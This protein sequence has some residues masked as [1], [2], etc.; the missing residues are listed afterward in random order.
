MVERY[1]Y[2]REYEDGE[3]ARLYLIRDN[4]IMKFTGENIPGVAAVAAKMECTW[5]MKYVLLLAPGV[6]T[7]HIVPPPV[8]TWGD[9]YESWTD[10]AQDLGV[11]EEEARRFAATEFPDIAERLDAVETFVREYGE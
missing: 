9:W 3:R 2:S 8:G 11:S 1:E 5:G 4:R 7:L 6:S 10:M